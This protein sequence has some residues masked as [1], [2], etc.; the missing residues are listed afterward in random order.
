MDLETSRYT[1][2]AMQAAIEL[3]SSLGRRGINIWIGDGQLRF[4]ASERELRQEDVDGLRSLKLELVELLQQP[5]F[6]AELP[7]RPRS[8]GCP[9]PLTAIQRLLW[10]AIIFN[11]NGVSR[12]SCTISE[13]ISGPLNCSLLQQ[14]IEAVLRRHESLRTRIITLDG[15]PLQ[16]VDDPR[17]WSLEIIDL[18]DASLP[19]ADGEVKRLAT[20]FI[21]EPVDISVGPLFDARLFTLSEHEHV[22]ILALDHL[23]TDAFSNRILKREIWTVYRQGLQGLPLS[24]PPL[25]LQFADYAVWQQKMYGVWQQR[26]GHYWRERLTDAPRIR[27]PRSDGCVEQENPSGA[28]F[29]MQFGDSVSAELRELA[30]RKRVLLSV[31][32]LT[33]YVAVISSWCDQNDVLLSMV[34]SNRHRPELQNTVGFLANLVLFRVEIGTND[35]FLDLLKRVDTEFYAVYEYQD[36]GLDFFSEYAT[37]PHFNWQPV[38]AEYWGDQQANSS[39]SRVQPFPFRSVRAGTPL[40]LFY[41]GEGGISMTVQYRTDLFTHRSVEQF[42]TN[43]RWFAEHFI[44]FPLASVKSTPWN[45]LE[46]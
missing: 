4:K 29:Q 28:L 40:P 45:A 42:C 2:K 9:I 14:S 37:E 20:A 12:R 27:L 10:N 26:Q 39:A 24:L 36:V 35:S 7:L 21:Q 1:N 22:L 34:L 33:I 43:L 15:V 5:A 30:K 13:R 44:Q 6:T 8:A 38:S 19:D 25:H 16:C 46:K 11:K 18:S 32:V 17:E 41:D 3:L 31:V 23:I